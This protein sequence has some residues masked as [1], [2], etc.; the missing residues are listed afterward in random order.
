MKPNEAT[1]ELIGKPAAVDNF[2]TTSLKKCQVQPIDVPI[3]DDLEFDTNGAAT[4]P[5]DFLP[6]V[7]DKL[8]AHWFYTTYRWYKY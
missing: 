5:C 3:Y 1:P 6:T 7:V 4:L 8:P 2:V